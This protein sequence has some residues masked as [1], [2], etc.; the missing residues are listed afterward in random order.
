VPDIPLMEI[1]VNG[2][3]IHLELRAGFFWGVER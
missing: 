1:P 3:N 2:G